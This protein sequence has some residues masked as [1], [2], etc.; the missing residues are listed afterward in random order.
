[1]IFHS[2]IGPAPLWKLNYPALAYLMNGQYYSEYL[3]TLRMMGLPVMSEKSWDK[4]V[5]WLAKHVEKLA[6]SSCR[7]VQ[8]NISK[9]GDML[10]W[11]ASFDGFYLTRGH[12]SNN[13][14]ATL[15]GFRSNKIAW[16]AYRTK[17]G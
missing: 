14:S 11:V 10:S 16:F 3:C 15:H 13:S 2:G 12:H 9:H 17:R 5:A 4:V 1:M 8:E 6:I 7:Q